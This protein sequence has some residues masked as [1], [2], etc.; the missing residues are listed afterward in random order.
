[1]VRN[2]A[3]GMSRYY[4]VDLLGTAGKEGFGHLNFMQTSRR[5]KPW[6]T[7]YEQVLHLR[8]GKKVNS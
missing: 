3:S 7:K 1:M 5:C 4:S 2:P 6:S 8:H